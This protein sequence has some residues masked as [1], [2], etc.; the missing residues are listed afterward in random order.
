MRTIWPGRV[1]S[2]M[3]I[4][5]VNFTLLSQN[6]CGSQFATEFAIEVA[7]ESAVQHRMPTMHRHEPR[8]HSTT[9]IHRTSHSNILF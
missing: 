1:D 8:H 4:H 3:P 9:A 2:A 6:L 5:N 7:T